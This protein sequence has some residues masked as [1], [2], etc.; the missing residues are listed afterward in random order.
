[1]K[2]HIPITIVLLCS[3]FFSCNNDD[4]DNTPTANLGRIN[5]Y[6]QGDITNAEAAAKLATEVGTLTENIYVQNTTQLTTLTIQ[7][8]GSMVGIYINFNLALDS[9]AI[10]GIT[11]INDF[12]F[13]YPGNT[14]S[15][16]VTIVCNDLEV[17]D[18]SLNINLSQ[19]LNNNVSFNDLKNI[20]YRI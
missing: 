3:L 19:N 17:I 18:N 6:I 7:G 9:I 2:K 15:T 20:E 16:P 4:N 11:R 1:M 10:N 13:N 14:I 8:K 5:V 12:E